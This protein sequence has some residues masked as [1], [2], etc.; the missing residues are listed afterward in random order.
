MINV[1]YM[2]RS[3]CKVPLLLS[4]FK[5]TRIF[6]MDFQ[7]VVKYHIPCKSVQWESSYCLRK[8]RQTQTYSIDTDIHLR[9]CELASHEHSRLSACDAASLGK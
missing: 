1:Q 8:D 2:C 3:A 7:K 4:D 6:P 9:N 5:E